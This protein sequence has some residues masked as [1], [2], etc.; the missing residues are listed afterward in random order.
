MNEGDYFACECKGT[1]GNP[2]AHVTW[3]KDNTK[4]GYTGKENKTLVLSNVTKDYC[5][6]Y[7]CVAISGI[8]ETKREREIELF[9]NCKYNTYIISLRDYGLLLIKTLLAE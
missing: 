4:I 9:V 3:Y 6:D 1:D 2:P 8:Q 5:G 7:T